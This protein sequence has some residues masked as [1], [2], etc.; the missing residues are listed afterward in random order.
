MIS[1][2][3]EAAAEDL[4]IAAFAGARATRTPL[5]P[6]LKDFQKMKLS[7]LL[8]TLLAAGVVACGKTEAPAPA[9]APKVEVP[10]AVEAPKPAEAPVAAPAAGAPA[11][12]AAKPADAPKAD[13]KP[14][15]APK[16]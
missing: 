6:V 11:A 10:K 4:R 9:P 15:E 5:T 1:S 2:W 12:D 7:Y 3:I 13:A 16:K 8:A 14:A